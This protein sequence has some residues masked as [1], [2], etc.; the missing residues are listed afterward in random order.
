M[1]Q[2]EPKNGKFELLDDGLLYDTYDTLGEAEATKIRLERENEI[3]NLAQE[4]M[5][6]ASATLREKF[7]IDSAEAAKYLRQAL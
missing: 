4:L 7:G 2:I 1:F 3:H 5:L 6:D